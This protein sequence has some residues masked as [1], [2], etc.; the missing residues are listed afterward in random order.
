MTKSGAYLIAALL[1][2]TGSA[3]AQERPLP[4]TGSHPAPATSPEPGSA[5]PAHAPRVRTD[6]RPDPARLATAP[7]DP[8]TDELG[9]ALEPEANASE[10]AQPDGQDGPEPEVQAGH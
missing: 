5:P 2:T 3:L 8:V 6:N 10:P 1:L 7:A 9:H 4:E